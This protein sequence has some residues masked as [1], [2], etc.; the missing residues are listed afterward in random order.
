M[1]E[2]Q[3]DTR[4]TL[5]V[6]Y[7]SYSIFQDL[8]RKLWQFTIF[9]FNKLSLQKVLHLPTNKLKNFRCTNKLEYFMSF[10][11][12]NTNACI[13]FMQIIH[14][15]V[16]MKLKKLLCDVSITN[17]TTAIDLSSRRKISFCLFSNSCLHQY[18]LALNV[19]DDD[20]EYKLHLSALKQ[21]K[22][23]KHLSLTNKQINLSKKKQIFPLFY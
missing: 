1:N 9:Y 23:E 8:T 10:Q 21:N 5:L 12:T 15:H 11:F 6:V 18:S 3:R 22:K 2:R 17:Y 7:L 20:D 14:K 16:T 19:N 4:K 13:S